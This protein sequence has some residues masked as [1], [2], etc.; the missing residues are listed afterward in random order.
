[1][2]K[3]KRSLRAAKPP[4][5]AKRQM[6]ILGIM[7]MLLVS[8]VTVAAGAN[9]TVDLVIDEAGTKKTVSVKASLLSDVEGVLDAQGY[10]LEKDYTLADN[11]GQKIKD[12]DEIVL[13]KA[14]SGVIVVDGREL[15]YTSKAETV[16]A[17]LTEMGI[18]VGKDDK[19]TPAQK[20]AL[21]DKITKITV[22][23]VEI[24]KET[25]SEEIAFDSE[26]VY[27]TDLEPGEVL[28]TT[29]GV[30][31]KR[32]IVDQVTYVNGKESKRA[33]VS[34]KVV[35]EPVNEV[36]RIGEEVI[37]EP[38]EEEKAAEEKA[39]A[40]AAAKKAEAEK[41]AKLEAE[42]KAKAE[43]EK[44]AQAEAA[45]K[46]EAEKKAKAE[47]EAKA[48]AEAEAK[49]QA[50]A[51]ASKPA[52]AP[53]P[54]QNETPQEIA[55]RLLAEYGWSNQ[56]DSLNQLIMHESSWN[57]LAEN[58]YSGAYGLGQSLPANKMASH[59]DD[60]RTN[61][62][63]QLRWTFDYIKGRYD[64]PNGAWSAWQRKGWY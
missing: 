34:K 30:P 53:A 32:E 35:L 1:M 15:N 27:T 33:E 28:V 26:E 20:T 60:W 3:T 11:T 40:E 5:M 57:P 54:A 63:T 62:E 47:A 24:K 2:K 14:P 49:A 52:P 31:G 25:R 21:T 36:T 6:T 50:E 64:D 7:I 48:K 37:V 46:A 51:E 18:T 19:V 4:K 23:R 61:P 9:K 17:L 56:W 45:K 8:G 16:G 12:V 55:K 42:K 10:D 43:A 29:V 39:A 44:K 59:G 13:K 22:D 58:P 41:Q 38:T